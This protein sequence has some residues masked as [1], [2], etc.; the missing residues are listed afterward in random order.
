M[1]FYEVLK[2]ADKSVSAYYFRGEEMR[3]EEENERPPEEMLV[4]GLPDSCVFDRQSMY[5]R[6][7]R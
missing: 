7:K 6:C 1:A 5:M 4:T 3:T 2:P